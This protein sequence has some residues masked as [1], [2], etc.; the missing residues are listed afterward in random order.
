[1]LYAA[2]GSNLNVYQ[3]RHRCPEADVVTT[4]VIPGY[5]LLYKGS[6]SGSYLTIEPAPGCEVPVGIWRVTG[7]DI[8][9]LNFYEG[10]PDFYY[11]RSFNIFCDDG[12]R[13]RVFAYIMHE[14][15]AWSDM[16][17]L[18][19]IPSIWM[20]LW[21]ILEGRWSHEETRSTPNQHQRMSDM[22]TKVYR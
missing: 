11:K 13:H 19:S 2:Y 15:R 14:D 9:A 1:M 3:M 21:L 20:R 7:R 10:Y 16:M 17:T 4:G 22:R 5:R 12:R 18:G 6:K 8:E